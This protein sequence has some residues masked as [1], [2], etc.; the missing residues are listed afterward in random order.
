MEPAREGRALHAYLAKGELRL[1]PQSKTCT[2]PPTGLAVDLATLIRQCRA[3]GAGEDMYIQDLLS[4]AVEW[5]QQYQWTQL[6]TATWENRWDCFPD[7][8]EPDPAPLL[9]VT[10]L[11][12][13]D[14]SGTTQTLT[15]NTDYTVDTKS[16][17]GR[18]VPA[19]GKSWPATRGHLNDV[20]LTFTA[21]YGTD[22]TTIPRNTRL[23]L[24]LL[25]SHWYRNREAVGMVEDELEFSVKSLLSLNSFRTWI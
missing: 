1:S 5:V 23:A 3:E 9:T 12:Y 22:D 25:V 6:L 20:I 17:P 15:A 10:S 19:Y 18:I 11:Q 7:V 8:I 13:V 24:M 14:T 21:G 2:T 4:A 16:R